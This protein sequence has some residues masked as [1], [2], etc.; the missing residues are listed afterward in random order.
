[1]R[2]GR[3]RRQSAG[4]QAGAQDKSQEL[5]GGA[6]R[7][8]GGHRRR[9]IT[10]TAAHLVLARI[11]DH[12]LRL[13]GND[14]VADVAGV[15][16]AHYADAG[17]LVDA[18]GQRQ[19]ARDRAER[20]CTIRKTRESRAPDLSQASTRRASGDRLAW[21]GLV[22]EMAA[23]GGGRQGK[24][25]RRLG[26]G[27]ADRAGIVADA[28][29]GHRIAGG[30]A[31]ATRPGGSR[32]EHNEKDNGDAATQGFSPNTERKRVRLRLV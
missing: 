5:R 15:G 3:G 18:V 16:T 32:Q 23:P 31:T 22:P 13:A 28:P 1:G 8:F 29:D 17:E 30:D 25:R 10:G 27:E 4:R 7:L 21:N 6:V 12:Q 26:I 14:T 9:L 19:Q 20:T 11:A 24:T 2:P